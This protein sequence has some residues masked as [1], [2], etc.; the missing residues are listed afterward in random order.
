MLLV[1]NRALVLQAGLEDARALIVARQERINA[2]RMSLEHA[3]IWRLGAPSAEFERVGAELRSAW[4]M[5]WDYLVQDGAGLVG[6]FLAILVLTAWLFSRRPALVVEP[7]Q[8]A[9]GRPFAAAL[10]IALVL[11]GWHGGQQKWR[12]P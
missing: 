2:Q 3:P 8:R 10:L 1:L 5:Q 12:F 4:Q 9:Y 7:V 11:L 6:L